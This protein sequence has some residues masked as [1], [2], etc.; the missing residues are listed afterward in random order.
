MSVELR[1]TND[2]YKVLVRGQIKTRIIKKKKKSRKGSDV[3]E[4]KNENK[5]KRKRRKRW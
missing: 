4:E 5:K 1:T 3:S 2:Y